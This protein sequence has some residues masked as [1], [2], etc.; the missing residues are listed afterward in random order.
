M[1]FDEVVTSRIANSYVVGTNDRT[2]RLM[3]AHRSRF[4]NPFF[5][6]KS[7]IKGIRCDGSR[8]G[9]LV[10]RLYARRRG[11]GGRGGDAMLIRV[12]AL[13]Q[14]LPGERDGSEGL[15]AMPYSPAAKSR[16]RVGATL[17]P[18]STAP[19]ISRS[20]ACNPLV[21]SYQT[22]QFLEYHSTTSR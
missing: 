12:P 11:R 16:P 5:S 2:I 14:D 3:S 1:G 7:Q 10:T 20:S 22:L 4:A 19:G 13:H 15:R 18:C 8:Q 17:E 6:G 9:G 21:S